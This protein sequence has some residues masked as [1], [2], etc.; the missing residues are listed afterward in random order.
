MTE[1]QY[2]AQ[3]SKRTPQG[4][5]HER[6]ICDN[7]GFIHYENP[8]LVTGSVVVRD[9]KILLCRRAIPPRHGHWTLPAG[10]MELHESAEASARREAYEEAFA[11]IEINALLAIYSI[12][13]ISQVQIIYRSRLL[14]DDFRPGTESLEVELFG[15]DEIPWDDLAFPSV[16]WALNQYHAVRNEAVFEPFSNP[17]GDEGDMTETSVPF[18]KR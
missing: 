7:C 6:N 4:D 2:K 17:P 16:H 8:K 13:R 15:W 18:E 3:F 9:G 10:F 11:D 14:N 1:N 12:P 5:T